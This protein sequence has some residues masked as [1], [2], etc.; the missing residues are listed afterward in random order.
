M[1]TSIV[2]C[3][4]LCRYTY[5]IFVFVARAAA[6]SA[7]FSHFLFG[8]ALSARLSH[9]HSIGATTAVFENRQVTEVGNT[10]IVVIILADPDKQPNQ[11]GDTE[12]SC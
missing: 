2:C 3:Q 12:R 10:S 9:A 8:R 1:G 5:C 6:I 7:N 11:V 4:K